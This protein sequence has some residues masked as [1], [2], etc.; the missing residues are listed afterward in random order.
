MSVDLKQIEKRAWLSSFNDGLLEI[1]LGTFLLLVGVSSYLS[2]M[3]KDYDLAFPVVYLFMIAIVFVLK[4]YVI[5][6]RAGSAVFGKPRRVNMLIMVIAQV[7]VLLAHFVIIGIALAQRD[8]M[9]PKL[10]SIGLWF[11]ASMLFFG[12]PAVLIGT[13][14]LLIYGILFGAAFSTNE[15]LLTFGH[16]PNGYWFFW[17]IG[18]GILIFG[19]YMLASF[20]SN[21]PLP[22]EMMKDDR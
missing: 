6:P 1:A 20:I 7:A 15:Y 19:L 17:G 10:S 2:R 16:S 11:V 4:L 22:S 5:K 18:G 9:V 8:P 12:L 21:N 14:R 13:P 3:G